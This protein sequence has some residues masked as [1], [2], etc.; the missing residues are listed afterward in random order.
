MTTTGWGLAHEA[1]RE[2]E[3]ALGSREACLAWFEARG[4]E[5]DPEFLVLPQGARFEGAAVLRGAVHRDA[6]RV[7]LL[8]REGWKQEPAGKKLREEQQEANHARRL[9]A[10]RRS[11]EGELPALGVLA[12]QSSMLWFPLNGDHYAQRLRLE[13]GRLRGCKEGGEFVPHFL[14]LRAELMRGWVQAMDPELAALIGAQFDLG[15]LYVGQGLDD[16]FVSRMGVVRQ[17]LVLHLLDPKHREGLLLGVLGRL[18]FERKAGEGD[19]FP[20]LRELAQQAQER[21]RLIA[22]ADTVLLRQVLYRYLERQFGRDEAQDAAE[23]QEGIAFG[24]YDQ[25]LEA[26]TTRAPSGEGKREALAVELLAM[27]GGLFGGAELVQRGAKGKAKGKGKGK[28]AVEEVPPLVVTDARFSQGVSAFNERY[29]ATAGGDLHQGSI[30]EAADLL[31]AHVLKHEEGLLA[32]LLDETRTAQY[33]F[34]FVD[35]EPRA[36]QRFYESTIGTDL[37]L[38]A[39]GEGVSVQPSQ[40]NRKEQGAYFTAEPLCF[41]MVDKTLGAL[42]GEWRGRLQG[43]LEGRKGEAE[44][45]REAV[46]ALLGEL[47][48]WKILDPTCGGGI[49][50]ASAFQRLSSWRA[51]VME[52][53]DGLLEPERSALLDEPALKALAQSGEWEWHVLLHM[54]YGVDKDIKA[55]N[56]ASN[57]LT[58]SSLA[59]KP[60]GVCFPSFINANLKPGNALVS[61]LCKADRRELHHKHGA[62]LGELM[63]LRAELRDH[64]TSRARW[65]E[66]HAELQRQT[67]GLSEYY[68]QRDLRGVLPAADQGEFL[69]RLRE[70]GV[71]AWE[72]EFPEVFYEATPEGG[73]KPKAR[74]GFDVV[75][76]NPPWEEPAAE[77]K[78]FL[79]EYD[80]GYREL[81]GAESLAREQQLLAD[82]QIEARWKAFVRSVDDY[83]ALLTAGGYQ[84]QNA[85]VLGRGQ[86]AHS[87]LYKYAVELAWTLLRED[88]R[89]GLVLDGGLWG[90][91]AAKPL[92]ALLLDQARVEAVVG[93]SNNEGL[94][95]D[96]HRSY[97][98]SATVFQKGGRTER[99]KA[100]FMRT[101]YRDL[102]RRSYRDPDPFDGLAVELDAEAIRASPQDTY[103]VPEVRSAAQLRALVALESHPTLRG[104]AWAVDTYSREL[105][106]GEQRHYFHTEEAALKKDLKQKL[107]NKIRAFAVKIDGEARASAERAAQILEQ[108]EAARGTSTVPSGQGW[109]PLVEGSQFNLFG[110]HQGS[111]PSEWVDP[112]LEGDTAGR[113]LWGR[114]EGRVLNGIADWLEAREGKRPMGKEERAREWIKAQTGAEQ[115]PAEWVRLDWEGYRLAWRDICRNDDKRTLIV[116]IVPP[117]V[118][119][120][121]T[122]P[123]VRPFALEVGE[124]GVSWGL[125]YPHERLL[126]L[127]GMLSSFACDSLARTRVTKTHLT[128]ATFQGFHVPA[129]SEGGL[130]RRV[131][132]LTARLTC[133]PATEERPWAEYGALA[134][135][136]GLEP[137]RDGLTD[138]RERWEAEVELNALA[139]QLYGLGAGEFRFLMDALFM[140][141]QHKAA[142]EQQ[143]DGVVGRLG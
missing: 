89:A 127:A 141:P 64:R 122:A 25:L 85:V 45:R 119:L 70:V 20:P 83:K 139:A 57:L 75:L 12:G 29:Q 130:Q 31:Q 21:R 19:G 74:P 118:A 132:E 32:K 121:H 16:D 42:F 62:T 49:F 140:T 90:D 66:V 134:A 51:E 77:F 28:A 35:L 47:M 120:S 26:T 100:V 110:V 125:Q 53:L 126:Y 33:S 92:R 6:P 46:R 91:I 17:R 3:A 4:Y 97:K 81:S 108:I 18:G 111:P 109:Y 56:V 80:A 69:A 79:G 131:A 13:P 43:V 14:G 10:S 124:G 112:R 107:S 87:N 113:F 38:D 50:L 76:G 30:S 58:L 54:L 99:F 5:P 55:L 67:Q 114:Q 142:H 63:R 115:T 143:R 8:W 72:F 59:Y 104:P 39:T 78:H 48:G 86:G 98:F 9:L 71:F 103:P 106:S 23:S 24:S 22:V 137:A 105:N 40:R 36:F 27:Q 117:R 95:A 11:S 94:F 44:G 135:S 82:A 128:S 96:I 102:M 136:V 93:F 88:G 101:S 37:K 2:L 41:W 73:V 7:L 129:W 65:S 15:R 138:T 1:A 123:F 116:A 133:L 34:E 60:R 68:A 61:P 84:H 52:E